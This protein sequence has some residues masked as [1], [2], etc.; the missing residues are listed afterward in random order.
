MRV[1]RTVAGEWKKLLIASNTEFYCLDGKMRPGIFG[2]ENCLHP[3]RKQ[4]RDYA[5]WPGTRILKPASR[6]EVLKKRM[7]AHFES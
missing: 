3:G 5:G 6:N 4:A 7:K 2:A 1:H